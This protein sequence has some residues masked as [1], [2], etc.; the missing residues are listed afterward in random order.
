VDEIT[1]EELVDIYS[2][3]T[4]N[5]PSGELIRIVLRPESETDTK[6]LRGLS[7]KMAAAV[8][9]AMDRPGL[10]VATTDQENADILE[11][12]PGSLGQVAVGQVATERRN[13]NVLSHLG[14]L[15]HDPQAHKH[16]GIQNKSLYVV[17]TDTAS[18][19]AMDFVAYVFSPEGQAILEG[20]DHTTAK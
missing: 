6:L 17:T 20:L 5:W 4:T 10:V 9:T 3:V 15:P 1:T 8:D 19:E 14:A 12:L 16:G 2:G 11:R 18:K 13:L 7:D